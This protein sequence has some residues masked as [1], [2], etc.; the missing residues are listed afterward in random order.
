MDTSETI[1]SNLDSLT[2]S[3]AIE[4]ILESLIPDESEDITIKTVKD[5]KAN[6]QNAIQD[7]FLKTVEQNL[8]SVYSLCKRNS[9]FDILA[10]TNFSDLQSFKEACFKAEVFLEQRGFTV[11]FED[12]DF[13]YRLRI[14]SW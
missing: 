2:S 7:F 8:R 6:S 4:S 9:Y 10:S 12:K 1:K 3:E 5:Y 11:N 13:E 14:S